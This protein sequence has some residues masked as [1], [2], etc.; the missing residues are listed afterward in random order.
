MS[1]IRKDPI[2]N[3]IH[4]LSSLERLLLSQAVEKGYVVF[5]PRNEL[6]LRKQYPEMT[7]MPEFTSNKVSTGDLMFIW[8]MRCRSSPFFNMTDKDKL[9]LCIDCAYKGE[10]MRDDRR[11]RWGKLKFEGPIKAAMERMASINTEVRIRRY[12]SAKMLLENSIAIV[13]EEVPKDADGKDKYIT[14]AMKAQKAIAE[15]SQELEAGSYGV[16]EIG[17][18]TLAAI[19]GGLK[20]HRATFQ[21][22]DA[23]RT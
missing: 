6:D 12:Q 21:L 23:V 19:M 20:N 9:D 11:T 5:A 8:F 15:I 7:K 14:R 13:A 17:N 22:Q 3:E 18:T 4:G 16:E 2:P 10:A 1:L